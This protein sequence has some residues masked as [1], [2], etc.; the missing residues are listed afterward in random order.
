MAA[1]KK[2]KVSKKPAAKKTVKKTAAPKK[3]GAKK[4]AAKKSPAKKAAAKKASSKADRARVSTEPHEVAYVAKKHNVSN[5]V[6]LAA[7]KRVGHLR[8]DVEAA[9][10]ETKKR[11]AAMDR[12]LV[13]HEPHE[14]AHLADKFNVS[15]EAVV[16]AIDEHGSSR[17]K[18]EAALTSP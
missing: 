14:V 2:A 15:N 11:S 8:V 5:E 6:V 16:A 9:I 10:A 18:V 12:A 13:S 3:V 1:K 7:I 17:K 4:P